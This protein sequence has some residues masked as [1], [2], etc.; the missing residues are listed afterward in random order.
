MY[1]F[2]LALFAA[3]CWGVAPLFGKLGLKGIYPMN[4][5]AART[6][7]TVFFVWGWFLASGN[8]KSITTISLR[9]WI[10]LGIEAFFATFV[11]DLA[12]YAAIKYGYMGETALILAASPLITLWLGY[13][14]LN[15]N[16]SLPKIIGAL[17]IVAGVVLIGLNTDY[18]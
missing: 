16:I 8:L 7:I 11:G 18:S 1:P 4:G 13:M 5:L 12:Y 14:I 15:E 3:I 10:L 2:F 17:L 6:V 9:A